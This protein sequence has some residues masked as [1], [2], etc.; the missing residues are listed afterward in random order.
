MGPPG[1]TDLP[2]ITMIRFT[3]IF[4]WQ[5][6]LLLRAELPGL[7]SFKLEDVRAGFSMEGGNNLLLLM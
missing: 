5:I 1:Q 2:N 3:Q 4:G 6:L 7:P